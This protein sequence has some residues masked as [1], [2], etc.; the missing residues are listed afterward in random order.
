M[1]LDCFID[2]FSVDNVYDK[3]FN[4]FWIL[5]NDVKFC[6]EV[7]FLKIENSFFGMIIIFF[8]VDYW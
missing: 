2:K 1:Y 3:L 6:K 5:D 8:N 7:F 4:G